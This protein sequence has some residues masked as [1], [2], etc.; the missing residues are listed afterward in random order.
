[1][2]ERKAELFGVFRIDHE[3]AVRSGGERSALIE[4]ASLHFEGFALV[5]FGIDCCADPV[6]GCAEHLLR[7]GIFRCCC[8]CVDLAAVHADISDCDLRTV[9]G[10]T[11]E[12]KLLGFGNIQLDQLCSDVTRNLNRF[13]FDAVQLDGQCAVAAVIAVNMSDIEAQ[14]LDAGNVKRSFLRVVM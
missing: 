7:R 1:M 9:A 8:G 10:L 13:G 3:L 12:N 2:A 14:L 11:D 6:I 4:C 5:R